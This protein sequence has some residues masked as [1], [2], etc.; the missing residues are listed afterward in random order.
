M[1]N[2]Q[3][4]RCSQ[5]TKPNAF[6]VAQSSGLI[7]FNAE[8]KYYFIIEN[9]APFNIVNLRNETLG[10]LENC[11]NTNEIELL[12]NKFLE[13]IIAATEIN[14]NEKLTFEKRIT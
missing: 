9:C 12:D 14:S 5:E 6:V 2:D 1:W 13:K 4:L 7:K 3:S 10:F 11:P 8:G